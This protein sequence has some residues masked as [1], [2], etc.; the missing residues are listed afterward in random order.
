MRLSS[1][2]QGGL[3]ATGRTNEGRHCIF[4]DVQVDIFQTL[5]G[6]VKEVQIFDFQDC[7]FGGRQCID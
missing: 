6:T 4:L 7:F 5:E 3:T 2:Q 1:A